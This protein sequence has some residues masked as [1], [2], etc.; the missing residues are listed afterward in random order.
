LP[1]INNFFGG[2]NMVRGFQVNG[3]GPRDLTPGTTLDAIGGTKYWAATV[4]L[5]API[6]NLPKDVGLKGAVFADAGSLWDYTGPVNFPQF[7]RS[8]TL[9]DPGTGIDTNSMFIRSAVGVG[10]IWESPFGPLRFDYAIP[11]TK[12]PFDVV[13]QFRFSGGTKF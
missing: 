6:P 3:F 11:I 2:P 8:L 5:Q 9:V 13:Q 1:I 10:L 12:Q 7:G 4:E